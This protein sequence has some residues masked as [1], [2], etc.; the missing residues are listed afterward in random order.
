VMADRTLIHQVIMNLCTNAAHAMEESGGVLRVILAD[1]DLRDGTASAHPGLAAGIYRQITVRDTGHGMDHPTLERI[2]DPYFT[3][4]KVGKG[5][6]LGLAVVQGIIKRHRGAISVSSEV[7]QGST[8]RVYLPAIEEHPAVEEENTAYVFGGAARILFVDDEPALTEIGEEMLQRLGY[9]V[10]AETDSSRAL[11]AFKK[12]TGDFDLVITDYTMPG[13]TG[14]ELAREILRIRPEMPI[15]LC[16][17]HSER[18]TEDK[19]REHGVSAFLMKPY[20][21]NDLAG[22]VREALHEGHATYRKSP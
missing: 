3:T 21:L 17:G 4:K 5:S 18:A 19:V 10:V 12:Q 14:L 8:F 15:V 16:T 11:V 2:F 1:V 7:G 22:K 20:D 9:E 6:G 13:M